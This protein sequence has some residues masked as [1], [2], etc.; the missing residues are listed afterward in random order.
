MF[1]VLFAFK[2]FRFILVSL[3]FV[4]RW[5]KA[6]LLTLS[7]ERLVLGS[8]GGLLPYPGYLDDT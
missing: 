4:E 6:M 7:K 1:L 3:S 5:G 8:G 2:D